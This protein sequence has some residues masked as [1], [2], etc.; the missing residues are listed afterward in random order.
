M[1]SR[2]KAPFKLALFHQYATSEPRATLVDTV[3]VRATPHLCWQSRYRLTGGKKGGDRMGWQLLSTLE[4]DR[5]ALNR[6]RTQSRGFRSISGVG[7]ASF[8]RHLR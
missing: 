1:S 2:R 7:V 6:V 8:I 5:H 3:P 4:D